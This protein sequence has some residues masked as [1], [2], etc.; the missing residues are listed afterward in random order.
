MVTR[1]TIIILS[2]ILAALAIIF[3][4]LIYVVFKPI[5]VNP[6]ENPTLPF[7]YDC[8]SNAY[9]CDT[10]STQADAQK[11]FED[12]GGIENDIH[13]LDKDGNG[14]ACESLE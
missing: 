13:G 14:L 10:F 7:E 4:A 8:S 3:L 12:C 2:S 6:Q 1:K 5:V 9:N 11:A